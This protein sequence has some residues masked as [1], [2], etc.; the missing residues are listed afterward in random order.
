M[1]AVGAGGAGG[2]RGVAGGESGRGARPPL[3][4]RAA[5][6]CP[7][8]T[9]PGEAALAAQPAAA[10]GT[11][12]SLMRIRLSA[13]T[14][15]ALTQERRRRPPREKPRAGTR[16]SL[17]ALWLTRPAAAAAGAA[18]RGGRPGAGRGFAPRERPGV[19]SPVCPTVQVVLATQNDANCLV[20]CL[21][22]CNESAQ[23]SPSQCVQ[24]I[25][26]KMIIQQ[27]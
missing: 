24:A 12:Y 17:D 3:R 4:H 8:Q 1:R 26:I 21:I 11:R 18:G 14:S 6:K 5:G 22:R 27:S 9:R 23:V 2:E 15:A 19:S 20:L 7:P 10:S 25:I 13:C 16:R